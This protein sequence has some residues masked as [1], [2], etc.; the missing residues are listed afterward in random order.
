M[1]ACRGEEVREAATLNIAA[2]NDLT[3]SRRG[4]G[5]EPAGGYAAFF[6]ATFITSRR[7]TPT[8]FR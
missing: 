5:A 2:S 6:S 8:D 3:L 1:S 7:D 4:A